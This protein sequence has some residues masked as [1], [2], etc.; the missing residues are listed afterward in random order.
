MSGRVV[1]NSTF[2][3][4]LSGARG[5]SELTSPSHPKSH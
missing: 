1:E 3:V 5:L 2:I 4:T